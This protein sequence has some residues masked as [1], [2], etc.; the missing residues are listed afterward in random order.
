MTRLVSVPLLT[1]FFELA[2]HPAK[3]LVI[4]KCGSSGDYPGCTDL[5]YMQA[6]ADGVDVL[7]C[8]VQLAKDGTPFCL[9]SINLIDNTAVVQS[10]FL[11]LTTNI[12]EIKAGSGIFTFSLTWSQIQTLTRKSNLA[13]L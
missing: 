12:P 7:D 13:C 3:P 4:S 2:H 11:N 8:P 5:A 6:I 1:F 10:S 9:G